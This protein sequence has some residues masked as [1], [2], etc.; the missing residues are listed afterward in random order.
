MGR[1]GARRDPLTY[2]MIH[3]AKLDEETRKKCLP[4]FFMD[5]KR[6]IME[7]RDFAGQD[8]RGENIISHSKFF[9]LKN[10]T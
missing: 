6:R 9:S 8:Q 5:K 4:G 3:L 2:D 7:M 1:N 10:Q